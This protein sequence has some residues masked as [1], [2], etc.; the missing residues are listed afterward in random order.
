MTATDAEA[1]ARAAVHGSVIA[2]TIRNTALAAGAW[3]APLWTDLVT[4]RRSR[5][6]RANDPATAE[7]E[8][9]ALSDVLSTSRLVALVWSPIRRI[10]RVFSRVSLP[11]FV[12][13]LRDQLKTLDAWQRVRL[14]G[15]VIGTAAVTDAMARIADPRAASVFRAWLWA[16]VVIAAAVFAFWPAQVVHAW[17][18]RRR[19]I[20]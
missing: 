10:G 14:A 9:A 19:T 2:G 11:P 17:R 20:R 3:I 1:R 12:A 6:Q 8:L 7:R 16:A 13:E 5:A 15:L 18:T 4:D